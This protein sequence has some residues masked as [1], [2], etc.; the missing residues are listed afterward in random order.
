VARQ[1]SK[2][3]PVVLLSVVKNVVAVV[4]DNGPG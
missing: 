4:V 3:V 2:K 1:P